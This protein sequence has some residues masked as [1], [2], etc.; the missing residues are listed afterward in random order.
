M[1]VTE[2]LIVMNCIKV[3]YLSVL[4]I[5]VLSGIQV[6]AQINMDNEIKT[7]FRQADSVSHTYNMPL[8]E[9]VNEFDILISLAFLVY[10]EVISSQDEPRC[11]FTPSCSEYAVEA[12]RKKGI[13]TGWLATFDRL[14]RCNRYALHSHYPF[15][16]E[17]KRFYDP[18]R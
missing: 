1:Y 8:K 3:V 6:R 18:V 2:N 5:A 9:S 14:S 11:V 17:K 4:L 12:F 10:K 15:D 7:L 13:V 16:K